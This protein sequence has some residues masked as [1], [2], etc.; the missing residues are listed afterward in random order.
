MRTAAYYA[1]VRV[2]LLVGIAAAAVD[3]SAQEKAPV[4]DA[5]VQ[6]P[7]LKA[8]REIYGDRFARAKTAAEK[9]A[10]AREILEAASKVQA[11]SVDQYVLLKIARDVATGAGDL[12]TALEAADRM[13]ERFDVPG[14]KARAD[15]L[16][17]AARRASSSAQHKAVAEAAVK[18]AGDLAAEQEYETAKK[19][20]ETAQASA[21]RARQ[22]ALVKKLT[23]L[24]ED[25]E[26]REKAARDYR[27]ALA[28][29]EKK[30]GDPAA[31]LAA[32]RYLCFIKGD[33]GR[34]VAMLALGSDTDLKGLATKDLKGAKSADE[35]AALGDAW[36]A[37]AE[38][39][40]GRE[41]ESLM[42]RAGSWYR[43][44][45][46]GVAAGLARVKVEKRLEQI[47]KLG[48]DIPEPSGGP[49]PAVAPFEAKK[50]K[51]FQARWAK[52]LKVPVVQTNSIGMK[53]VLIPPGE[54]EMGSTKEEVQE[55]L[56]QAKQRNLPAWCS[57]RIESESPE[58]HVKITKAFCLGAHEVTVGQFRKFVDATGYRT[59]AERD[60][61]GGAGSDAPTPTS[62]VTKPEPTW[63]H[64]GFAQ[65]DDHPVLNVSW[66]DAGAFCRWLSEKERHIYDLATEAEWEYA[67][68]A[69]TNTRYSFGN[70]EA[71]LG[72]YAW[73]STNSARTTHPVG[74]KRP[75]AWGAF[76]MHG[77]LFEWCKDWYGKDYYATGP[78]ED[79]AGPDSEST[80]V[81]RSAS[82]GC[83]PDLNRSASR[84]S[85]TPDYRAYNVGFRIARTLAP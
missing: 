21:R 43:Q 70:E 2:I 3:L 85:K 55:L 38:S 84:G 31:N 69:G 54:F 32:G 20:C 19:L 63:R 44:A 79:P 17:A 40:E 11:G 68:R 37:L 81:L 22:Y 7:V 42:L 82:F 5:E 9:G 46:P 76:D 8:A 45:E 83:P 47:S 10:L 36:W 57:F 28:G 61:K 27:E 51:A 16:L 15:V 34:G 56:K 77:N 67:C 39:R 73:F 78:S 65:T 41:R 35:Q 30:P 23:A 49:P 12:L 53:L 24:A 62:Q 58:H 33:W 59:D 14:V 60:A 74:R 64:V 4:P 52:H 80:R 26:Q 1:F 6:G 71:R 25:I 72:E 18:V 13:A 48:R 75:N 29:V 66:N 50:A